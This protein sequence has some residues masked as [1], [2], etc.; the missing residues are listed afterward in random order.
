[1]LPVIEQFISL[2]GEGPTS[3][4]LAYFVRFEQC[5][6]RCSWCDTVYSW[7]GSTAVQHK[8][9][10]QIYDEIKA[11]GIRNVTLTGGEPLIQEEIAE[12]LQLLGADDSLL[13]HI[14]TNGSV[15]IAPFKNTCQS[16]NILYILDYKL[17]ESGMENQMCMANLNQVQ[18]DDVYKF[19]IA[20]K[21]DLNRAIE[22]VK[23]YD[24]QN[25]CQV[26][27]SPV[28]EMIEPLLIVDKMKEECLNGVRLQ[29][30]LHKI[31]WP[32]EMRGV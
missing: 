2:D 28:R 10:Q 25:R 31:L 4:E 27:F 1:M 24:L 26:F 20:S 23:A 16:R 12:L 7:D 6:L 29:L 3:G 19:V 17:P 30:Q 14:E 13:V 5:N 11:S 32:K 9:A 15:D 21:E 18:N 22:I 8:T